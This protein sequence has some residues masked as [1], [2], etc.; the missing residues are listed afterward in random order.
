MGQIILSAPHLGRG[1]NLV[2]VCLTQEYPSYGYVQYPGYWGGFTQRQRAASHEVWLLYEP[3]FTH[4]SQL[5][6]YT[7]NE[8]QGGS[9]SGGPQ[10]A[11]SEVFSE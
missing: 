1:N 2:C 9:S 3:G 5:S 7:V 10:V 4:V 6:M 8:L 11:I